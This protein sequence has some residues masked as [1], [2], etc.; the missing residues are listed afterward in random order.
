MTCER[1]LVSFGCRGSGGRAI[2]DEVEPAGRLGHDP[3]PISVSISMSISWPCPTSVE[4]W[5]GEPSKTI[6]WDDPSRR[7]GDGAS[8]ACPP[9]T[10]RA[11][12]LDAF[13]E[14]G[15][16]LPRDFSAGYADG[17]RTGLSLGGGGVYFVAWQ[18]AYL[19][20]LDKLG[21]DLAGADRI[22]GTSAGSIVAAVLEAGNI[23]R[24]FKE[25]NL[26]AKA[27]KLLSTLAP[28][29]NLKPSQ[30]RSRDLFAGADNARPET[31]QAIGHSALAADTPPATTMV[32]NLGMI[33]AS[34]R[35][36]SSD[37]FISCADT[38]TGERC[39]VTKS[40]KVP[41][42]RAVA[43][44]SA[45][46]G[47][48]PPQPV[49]DRFCMDGGVSGTGIHLDVLAGAKRAVVIALTDGKDLGDGLDDIGI[50]TNPP[51]G[52]LAELE[53]LRDSGTD[54]FFRKPESFDIMKLMDPA[55]VP[56]ALAMG[57]R[58]ARADA[59]DLRSFLEV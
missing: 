45:V 26:L 59:D 41:I 42:A 12:L 2:V 38:Y 17:L 44:S 47:V 33:L 10:T 56:E 34:R 23:G 37:L 46:P 29:G 31:L 57:K 19:H 43:A 16:A 4:R 50:M 3:T 52:V 30:I 39:L 7:S 1:P 24:F 36:P 27:P 20:Q 40:A 11:S 32:R 53:H 8:V 49:G 54:V 15:L 14:D 13:S 9:M 18:V 6:A 58:Q 5:L 21:V 35:W 51:G 28:A 55:A 25:A 48:F 22:V